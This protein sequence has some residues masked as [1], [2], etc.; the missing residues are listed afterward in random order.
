[1]VWQRS[2]FCGMKLARVAEAMNKALGTCLALVVAGLLGLCLA[3]K[4]VASPPP[5]PSPAPTNSVSVSMSGPV[6]NFSGLTS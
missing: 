3:D 6:S 2:C 5:L 1:M 4:S